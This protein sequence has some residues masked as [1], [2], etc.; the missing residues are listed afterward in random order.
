MRY[1]IEFQPSARKALE[2]LPRTIQSRISRAINALVDEPH[3]YGSKKL[4]G[5]HDVWRIRVGDYRVLYT[6]ENLRL[7]IWVLKIG[8]RREVYR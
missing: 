5:E 2:S 1:S 7:V 6:I 4:S 8:H 3:P